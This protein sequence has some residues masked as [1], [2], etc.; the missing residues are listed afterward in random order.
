MR[1][2]CSLLVGFALAFLAACAPSPAPTTGVGPDRTAPAPD[3]GASKTLVL[4][5]QAAP[6]LI[7]VWQFGNTFGG[8]ASLAE[9]HTTG[10][11][12]LDSQGNPTG[13]LAVALPS[14][15]DG[16]VVLLPDGRL[17]TTWTL[18]PNVTWQDGHPFTADDVAFTHAFHSTPELRATI[19]SAIPYIERV[20]TPDPLT[21]V[22]T[23][24]VPYFG[25]LNLE[26]RGMWLMPKHLLGEALE[27]DKEAV[28][29]LP[30]FT[31]EYVHLGPFRLVD[32]GL[33]QNMVFERYEQYFLGRPRVGKI[34]ILAI[35]DA[36]TMVANLLAGAVDLVTER[37]IPTNLSLDI[38][39][40][41]E[42]S[43]EG[44]V[45]SRPDTW[46]Y[47]W[48]QF[49]PALA[50]PIELSQDVRVRQGLLFGADRASL[51]EFILP[52]LP[53]T[54][55]DTFMTANDP[56]ASLVGQPFGRYP[57]DPARA[58]QALADAGLQRTA[59]GRILNA[60]GVGM[61]FEL[62]AI[63]EYVN[64]I[65]VIAADW[66]KLGFEVTEYVP[67]GQLGREPEE[68]AKFPGFELR[69]RG[70][71]EFVFQSFDSREAATAQNRF[72]G[73]NYAHYAN[74]ALDRLIDRLYATLAP[75]DRGPILKEM[76]ELIATDLP[77]LPFY[78]GVNF[79]H[80]RKTI[81]GPL[82]ADFPRTNDTSGGGIGRSAHLWER[83]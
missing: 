67:S 49:D 19:N 51:R 35:P 46:N 18:R 2:L 34:T 40:E 6:K 74:P 62:R 56:R 37:A 10:L 58:A 64:V 72:Q 30:Y 81:A 33:G 28:L 15:D 75:D 11:V 66:R 20:D 13:R 63:P 32:W 65:A 31:T 53:D 48:L 14:F 22:I 70:S 41:W 24:K 4:A 43:G 44:V 79:L 23:W 42:R 69:R 5:Q 26:H 80:V 47:A 71:N 54:S 45:I 17:R 78:F 77:M 68:Q 36:N 12:T 38:K 39:A 61:Q 50:R 1:R 16:S 59:D 9:I 73:A 57:H 52:G 27:G 3:D 25:A 21:A 55:A 29:G 76:G 7:G 8:G 60:A 83:V 82:T